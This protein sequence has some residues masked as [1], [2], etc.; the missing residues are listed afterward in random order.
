MLQSLV[1]ERR[2]KPDL[3]MDFTGSQTYIKDGNPP[4]CVQHHDCLD[5]DQH[6]RLPPYVARLINYQF[7]QSLASSGPLIGSGTAEDPFG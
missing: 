6:N 5:D 3:L 7:G 4:T 2:K 1:S